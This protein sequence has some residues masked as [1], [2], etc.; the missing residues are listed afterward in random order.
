MLTCN[1]HV[2]GIYLKVCPETPKDIRLGLIVIARYRSLA[3]ILSR[4][5]ADFLLRLTF[6]GFYLDRYDFHGCPDN[7]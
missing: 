7:I 3:H 2:A 4:E 1:P 5:T 6:T